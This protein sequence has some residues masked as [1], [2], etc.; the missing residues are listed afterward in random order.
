MAQR[1]E[2]H[3]P[4]EEHAGGETAVRLAR[5]LTLADATLLGVGA[6][7]GGGI[8]VLPGIAAGV[9]GPALFLALALNAIVTIPTLLAYAE[10]ASGIHD[11]GGGYL[12]VRDALGN[13]FG[14][15]G[16]WMSWFSHALACG[17]YALAS[18]SYLTWM[19][20]R[21]SGLPPGLD[22]ATAVKVIAVSVT[23]FFVLLNYVGV[24]Q[25]ARA[26]NLVTTV[27]LATLGVFIAAGVWAIWKRPEGLS[28][29]H[30]DAP[31]ELAPMGA[32]GV[33]LAM[34]L[35]FIAFEGYE[36]IAQ[37]SEEVKRPARN[38]P[39]ASIL[40]VAIVV[41]LLIIVAIIALTA[42]Q[43]PADQES[44]QWLASHK[45]LALVEAAGQFVPFGV[46]A[47]VVVVGAMLSNITGL[48]STIY[49]SSR[50]SFAMGRDRVL[51]GFFSR[52]HR[53]TQTPT[54]SILFSG[55]L[56]AFMAAALPIQDVAAAADIMFL[57]LFTLVNVSY[58]KLRRTK[59]HVKFGFRAPFFPYLP[60]FGIVTKS[61][62]AI[63]LV[64]YSPI[65]AMAALVWVAAGVGVHALTSR[66]LEPET[67]PRSSL[68]FEVT[69][70]QRKGYHIVLPVANPAS[71]GPLASIARDLARAKGGGVTLLHIITVPRTTLPSA[72]RHLA[73]PAKPLLQQAARVFPPDVPVHS[74]IMISH[75]PATAILETAE[76]EGADVILLG[77]RGRPS[78]REHVLGST[79]DPVVREAP[80]DVA[81]LRDARGGEPRRVVI[82]ARGRGKHAKRGAE[83]AAAIA[84]AR[85]AELV[86]VTV[87]TPGTHAEPEARLASVVADAGVHPW[88]VT[89][90]SVRAPGAESGLL[91][92]A[93]PGDLLVLGASEEPAWRTHLFGTIPERVA[94]R[95]EASVLLVKRQ[96]PA[97]RLVVRLL[98]KVRA[99]LEYLKPER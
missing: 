61:A 54:A 41:P 9:A 24:K 6:L 3:A 87:V 83:L 32:M 19:L 47:I 27:V 91:A 17:V 74:V 8:F 84:K 4:V 29:L 77:W 48:N 90:K 11:A 28:Q 66:K 51:P 95:S 93:G 72:A 12:W 62:L 56:I 30:L 92:A 35:T 46:G 1:G 25:A 49:S 23:G 45:E 16:G 7:V 44:W 31:M 65:A 98:R 69:T 52:V 94:S 85:G 43:V 76:E 13:R 64:I 81:V 26:E 55:L 67:R 59:K 38:V 79:L 53:R 5:D 89:F 68:S 36:I 88:D 37:A 34:G 18:A 33:F 21:Y 71:A 73:D 60:L 14:F 20:E 70:A 57:L 80:C 50:V 2:A 99:A 78:L 39:L 86:A 40:S 82:A 63:A 10:L 22:H 97:A 15:L 42:I 75:D 96:T 58:I